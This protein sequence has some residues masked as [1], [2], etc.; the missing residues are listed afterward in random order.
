[1]ATGQMIDVQAIGHG[2]MWDATNGLLLPNYM[3]A[4]VKTTVENLTVPV[5]DLVRNQNVP[6][7]QLGDGTCEFREMNPSVMAALT[8]GAAVAG[9]IRRIEREEQ[10]VAAGVITVADDIL[11][12][13]RLQ[14]FNKTDG[15]RCRL[16]SGAPSEANEAQVGTPTADDITFHVDNNADVMEVSYFAVVAGAGETVTIETTD[17]P[18][19]FDLMFNFRAYDRPGGAYW[20][21]GMSILCSSCR[22][23]GDFP[24]V[25]VPVREMGSFKLDFVVDGDITYY[26]P[27]T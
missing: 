17:L 23:T 13:D 5:G 12:T 4:T 16:V 3:Q 8:G 19:A 15:K 25:E 26:N 10:T 24:L 22:R 9:T 1:M 2:L 18:G 7:V 27:S 6:I 14:I 20:T 11:Y 21:E